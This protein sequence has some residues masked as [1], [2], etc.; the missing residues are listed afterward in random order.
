MQDFRVNIKRQ[1][2]VLIVAHRPTGAERLFN[3]P[4]PS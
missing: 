4:S 3:K 2:V 1:E